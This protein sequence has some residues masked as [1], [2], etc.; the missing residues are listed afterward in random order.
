MG[1]RAIGEL[2][3][4]ITAISRFI[5]VGLPVTIAAIILLV[6]GYILSSATDALE[7]LFN[8]NEHSNP[9][10][11]VRRGLT[12]GS[13]TTSILGLLCICL[14]AFVT[15]GSNATYLDGYTWEK[16]EQ[17]SNEISLAETEEDALKIAEN[18][19]LLNSWG[20]LDGSQTKTIELSNGTETTVQLIGIYHDDSAAAN[21]GKLGLTFAFSEA[22]AERAMMNDSSTNSGGWRDSDLRDW[23]SKE[24]EEQ[25]PE[26]LRRVIK[27]ALKRTNNIG[28]LTDAGAV[29]QTGD[30]LW[31]LSVSECVGDPRGCSV[32]SGEYDYLNDIANAEGAQYKLFQDTGVTPTRNSGILLREYIGEMSGSGNIYGSACQWWLRSPSA[33]TTDS[34]A[35]EFA[36][37]EPDG[38][39]DAR[40]SLG[41]A[42]CFCI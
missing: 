14:A 41:V 17:I 33:W 26:D 20:Q 10:L 12:I 32:W 27:P 24:F 18:Y 16:L 38:A 35:S 29:D 7:R 23:L 13:I 30:R 5:D 21:G 8:L 6:I 19:N 34:F 2:D 1:I 3:G 4:A 40:I 37:D 11:K 15:S 42:P 25:L 22:I 9:L 28:P 36:G 31:L 39:T